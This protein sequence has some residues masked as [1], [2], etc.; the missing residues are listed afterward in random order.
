MWIKRNRQKDCVY[1]FSVCF[2]SRKVIHLYVLKSTLFLIFNLFCVGC[3]PVF[4]IVIHRQIAH[5]RK[6]WN[7]LFSSISGILIFRTRRFDT[8][9][10]NDKIAL[11]NKAVACLEKEVQA[12]NEIIREQACVI[13]TLQDH[14]DELTALM[15]RILNSLKKG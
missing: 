4:L 14:N 5:M 6:C 1:S 12:K 2:V 3:Q 11:L 8:M 13:K 10:N 7:S 9:Q 15:N